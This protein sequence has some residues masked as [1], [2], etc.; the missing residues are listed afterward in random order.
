MTGLSGAGPGEP[1]AG[2]SGTAGASD[3]GFGAQPGGGPQP[4]P[5]DLLPRE[6]VRRRARAVALTAAVLGGAT[7]GMV[8]WA[9]GLGAGLAAA[10]LAGGPLALLA[11]GEVRRRSW[12][13]GTAVAA[14]T[15]GVR[16]VELRRAGRTELLV[17]EVRGQRSVSLLVAESR[18]AAVTVPLAL[19]GAAGGIELGVLG[20]RRLADALAATAASHPAALVLSGL[21]VAQLRAEARSVPLAQRPLYLA[22]ALAPASKIVRSVDPGRL[23]TLVAE[24]T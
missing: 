4:V 5:L 1:E 9:A 7:G 10:L 3:G 15:L 23:A 6:L 19:Y 8:G 11:L 18:R 2:G 12:L 13:V 14:R 24:L 20:L 22:A 17:S 21:L 16:R